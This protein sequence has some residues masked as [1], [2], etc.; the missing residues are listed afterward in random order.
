[1]FCVTLLC[2]QSSES[3]I[4]ELFNLLNKNVMSI[5][6]IGVGFSQLG[7]LQKLQKEMPELNYMSVDEELEGHFGRIR[8][9]S[10]A[11]PTYYIDESLT[12]EIRQFIID[13]TSD[14]K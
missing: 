12:E 4:A 9:S 11:S 13:G 1:M 7:F 3:K 5:L 10:S 14:D 8:D 2:S 6:V